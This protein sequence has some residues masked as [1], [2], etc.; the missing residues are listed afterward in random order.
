VTDDLV[1]TIQSH[2]RNT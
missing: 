1:Q 2:F